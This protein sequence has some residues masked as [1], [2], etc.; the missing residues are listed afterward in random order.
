MLVQD[1]HLHFRG[2][3][4]KAQDWTGLIPV[5][6]QNGLPLACWA[7]DWGISQGQMPSGHVAPVG[8]PPA[9]GAL[10]CPSARG[11][12]AGGSHCATATPTVMGMK[13]RANLILLL[14]RPNVP[15][16][17][18]YSRQGTNQYADTSWLLYSIITSLLTQVDWTGLPL[19]PPFEG[20]PGFFVLSMSEIHHTPTLCL[21][22]C[23][24]P[25]P[26]LT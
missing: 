12:K 21:R 10:P 8:V 1:E 26:G 25:P 5:E 3:D 20:K 17:S 7:F 4:G 15:L 2:V 22:A 16:I 11:G 23:P 14:P 24:P 13:R 9:R 19:Q 18:T 6:A